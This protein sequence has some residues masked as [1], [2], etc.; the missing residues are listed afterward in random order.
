MKTELTKEA[1]A[2]KVGERV[3]SMGVCYEAVE[4]QGLI[5]GCICTSVLVSI[6]SL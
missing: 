6:L 4:I 1:D 5:S 2:D 3:P